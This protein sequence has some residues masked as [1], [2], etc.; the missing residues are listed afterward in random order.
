MTINVAL[1]LIDVSGHGV[2]AAMHS[3]SVANILRPKALSVDL[4]DP[5]A[6]LESL[7]EAFPM[8]AHDDMYFTIWYGVYSARPAGADVLVRRTPSEPVVRSRSAARRA[9]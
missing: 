8:D 1:Y 7:N 3:V 5:A 9:W 2:S 4:R 6:V